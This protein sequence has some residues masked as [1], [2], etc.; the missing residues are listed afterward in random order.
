M[1]RYFFNLHDGIDLADNVGSEHPDLQSARSEA[2]ET[3]A[4][5]LK[6][7]MLTKANVSAWIMNVTDEDGY[8]VIV[9][10]FSAA[11]QIIDH[12][13]LATARAAAS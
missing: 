2:I 3:I 4:E 7:S 13:S 9:L 11:V 12:V 5:R 10:S 6:G 8:T 1:A